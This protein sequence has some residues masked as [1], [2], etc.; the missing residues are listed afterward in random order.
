MTA[1]ALTPSSAAVLTTSAPPPP[2]AATPRTDKALIDATRPFAV[3]NRAA[4]WWYLLSTLALLAV[5]AVIAACAPYLPVRIAAR[6]VAL[7]GIM[8]TLSVSM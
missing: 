3:E 4:S 2:M 6:A 1:E 7:S 5:A 8:R